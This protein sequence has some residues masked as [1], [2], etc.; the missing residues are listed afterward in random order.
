MNKKKKL[1]YSS[2]KCHNDN[3]NFHCERRNMWRELIFH[4]SISLVTLIV[5]YSWRK[6]RICASIIMNVD[7]KWRK[8]DAK[9]F[10]MYQ[11]TEFSGGDSGSFFSC[12]QMADGQCAY[13]VWNGNI[14]RRKTH[15]VGYL[16]RC[17]DKRAGVFISIVLVS[18]KSLIDLV[19]WVHL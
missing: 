3:E 8:P 18:P 5:T 15:D 4:R 16:D 1:V 9:R 2:G 10:V 6:A 7:W 14:I 12:L 13:S 17:H 11:L 19:I